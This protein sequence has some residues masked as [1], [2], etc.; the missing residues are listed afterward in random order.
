VAQAPRL[1]FAL[2]HWATRCP[3]DKYRRHSQ[4]RI[5]KTIGSAAP[6]GYAPN[7]IFYCMIM[8]EVLIPKW[9]ETTTMTKTECKAAFRWLN[10]T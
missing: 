8:S 5:I 7:M 3:P 1:Q 10:D 4:S 6:L 9:I 2:Q